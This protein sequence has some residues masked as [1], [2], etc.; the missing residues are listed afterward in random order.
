MST[1]LNLVL[2]KWTTKSPY[3]SVWF[4]IRIKWKNNW[5]SIGT[6]EVGVEFLFARFISTDC[7]KRFLHNN[8]NTF[9]KLNTSIESQRIFNLASFPYIMYTLFLILSKHNDLKNVGSVVSWMMVISAHIWLV[10]YV[11]FRYCS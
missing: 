7:C 4:W 5:R 1:T 11:K 10:Y 6:S 8:W 2:Q 9:S 3:F